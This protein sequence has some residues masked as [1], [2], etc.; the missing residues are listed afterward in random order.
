MAGRT[1]RERDVK[2]FVKAHERHVRELLRDLERKLVMGHFPVRQAPLYV[3]DAR[4]H[5]VESL[6]AGQNQALS[7][8]APQAIEC[9]LTVWIFRAPT[10]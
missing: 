5:L 2:A 6:R 3:A 8:R 10:L 4:K 1:L 9:G 7:I